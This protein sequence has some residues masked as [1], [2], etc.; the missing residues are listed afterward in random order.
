MGQAEDDVKVRAGQ[1]LG[2]LLGQ[3]L[4]TR[5]ASTAW[6]GPVPASVVLDDGVVPLWARQ[7]V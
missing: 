2:Q 5:R 3:P 6:A 4:L 7:K 1:Q